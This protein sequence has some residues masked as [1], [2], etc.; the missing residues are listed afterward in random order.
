M[1]RITKIAAG[2]VL[3]CALVGTAGAANAYTL[4]PNG[5]GFIGKGEVQ[6]ALGM[7]NAALQK[8]VDANALTFTSKQ[9]VSQAVS[10]DATQAG[11]QAGV[12]SGLQAGVQSA[13]QAGTQTVSWDLSCTIDNKNKQFH[14][15]GTR[16]GVRAGTAVGSRTAERDAVRTAD[17]DGVRTGTRSGVVSG[18]VDAD[19]DAKARKTGQWTGWNIKGMTNQKTT[20][21]EVAVWNEPTTFGDWELGAWSQ[22]GEWSAAGDWTFGDWSFGDYSFGDVTW[23]GWQNE[24]GEAPGDCDRG[25][26]K[27]INIVETITYG[28]TVNGV[29]TPGTIAPGAVVAGDVAEAG[30]IVPGDVAYID[31]VRNVGDMT[32]GSITLFVNGKSLGT[33]AV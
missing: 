31:P 13:T 25:N 7:N 19:I 26:A 18:V 33:P 29:I 1:R 12:Q 30:D 14:R 24:P 32:Y 11:T 9:S 21:S 2:T 8:A 3:A 15:E 10:Q 6:T 22:G 5:T 17:R 28:A 20:M 23:G 16:D 27:A 4:T